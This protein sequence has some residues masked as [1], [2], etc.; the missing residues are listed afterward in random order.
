MLECRIIARAARQD[1]IWNVAVLTYHANDVQL[2][3]WNVASCHVSVVR[4]DGM[5]ISAITFA[6]KAVWIRCVTSTQA[7]A[8]AGKI[9]LVVCV[10]SVL[11]GN[12]DMSLTT[13]HG[14]CPRNCETYQ[15]D[16]YCTLCQ[17]GYY[18]ETREKRLFPRD[19]I[20]EPYITRKELIKPRI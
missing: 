2:P 12:M 18:G 7:Y 20:L 19:C 11:T 3:A 9:S 17:D 13:A 5:E 14:K 16:K 10:T 1:F 4:S 15:S 8:A 6:E